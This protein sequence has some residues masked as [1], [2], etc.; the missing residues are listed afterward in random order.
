[1]AP[2]AASTPTRRAR[3]WRGAVLCALLPVAA[4]Q[5]LQYCTL[6]ENLGDVTMINGHGAN[7]S[8]PFMWC[9]H[10]LNDT[11]SA[12]SSRIV[13]ASCSC[14]CNCVAGCII[15][16]MGAMGSGGGGA[17]SHQEPPPPHV[18]PHGPAP[19]QAQTLEAPPM[20]HTIRVWWLAI[21]VTFYA[22]A[23]AVM[24]AVYVKLRAKHTILFNE[25]RERG[26][27]ATDGDE[28][29][30]TGRRRGDRSSD[31]RSTDG[32][33]SKAR[34]TIGATVFGE[35]FSISKKELARKV[36]A[37]AGLYLS[38]LKQCGTFF[39]VHSFTTFPLLMIVY[40][41]ANG[42]EGLH[43]HAPPD[44]FF[45]FTSGNL[46]PRD[47]GAKGVCAFA[48]YALMISSVVFA[49]RRWKK[50]GNF[51]FANK[52]NTH[53]TTTVMISDFPREINNER[54]LESYFALACPQQVASMRVALDVH[55]LA[56]NVRHQNRCIKQINT[57]RR[58][59]EWLHCEDDWDGQTD[60]EL[61]A[62]A[63]HTLLL[64]E[65]AE[66]KNRWVELRKQ[67]VKG[68]GCA[69][70]TFVS[71]QCAA[72]FVYEARMNKG[73]VAGDCRISADVLN[74]L[75]RSQWKISM[76][77]LQ[78]DIYWENVAT[79]KNEQ[80]LRQ[81]GANAVLGAGILCFAGAVMAG[82]VFV[83]FDYMK[84]AHRLDP[85][86]CAPTEEQSNATVCQLN[87]YSREHCD[88][89]GCHYTGLREFLQSLHNSLGN[90]YYPVMIIP[91]PLAFMF[92]AETM[93]PLIQ[94][95]SGY[96]HTQTRTL[97][98][99]SYL[100]KCYFYYLGLHL[101]CGTYG[102]W[103]LAQHVHAH[104]KMRVFVDLAG[105]YFCNKFF[106]ES[107]FYMPLRVLAGYDFFFR[108]TREITPSEYGSAA[109]EDDR[110]NLLLQTLTV[111]KPDKYYEDSFDYSR[112]YGETIALFCIVQVYA[113]S[114][115]LI[116]PISSCWFMAKYVA[117]KY[118]L[119]RQYSRARISYGRRARMITKWTILSVVIGQFFL[120][121]FTSSIADGMEA[122]AATIKW[123]FYLSGVAYLAYSHR[124]IKIP[125]LGFEIDPV[126]FVMKRA[127]FEKF[128]PRQITNVV[129]NFQDEDEIADESESAVKRN[130]R[131]RGPQSAI[132]IEEYNVPT[133]KSL[134]PTEELLEPPG[135]EHNVHNP[136]IASW[137]EDDQEL[138]A[139]GANGVYDEGSGGGA[140]QQPAHATKKEISFAGAAGGG[141]QVATDA[142]L[143]YSPQ[144]PRDLT[145]QAYASELAAGVGH[146][147]DSSW[148]S[149]ADWQAD[150]DQ[151][152]P[153]PS[154]EDFGSPMRGGRDSL[155]GSA[156]RSVRYTE[157]EIEEEV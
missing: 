24:M 19:L 114:V 62:R 150:R 10:E 136:M 69:F 47:R 132:E 157:A 27:I 109:E 156:N 111:F 81:I 43:E 155:V 9:E 110:K 83:G 22:L 42:A 40:S 33:N 84:W 138:P 23:C 101:G 120:W 115:P 122:E 139:G 71:E 32:S 61:D 3:V 108:P 124:K 135:T 5:R 2:S 151:D 118:I 52:I 148:D 36:G 35:F 14:S 74:A 76:A 8:C 64:R 38:H 79:S 102:W 21:P 49:Y 80:T 34:R 82:I 65:L 96:E 104:N 73:Y 92:C 126:T 45:T 89:A 146:D 78:H 119:A 87:D 15:P 31:P 28:L 90:W 100:T 154:D 143:E 57:L 6:V 129:N 70:I 113:I 149:D 37:D 107:L 50:L 63:D 85:E 16:G 46:G 44:A 7:E 152:G 25:M 29:R 147:S 128:M 105:L 121:Y 68:G 86:S 130:A 106:L 39:M 133:M 112:Q 103:Y 88:E 77:P 134:Q 56:M 58:S 140:Y 66:L 67:A 125:V 137:D 4:A 95:I 93:C 127:R 153:S 145:S 117:D 142:T 123:S 48:A 41:S 94:W 30:A 20:S 144:R 17:H 26:E 91:A 13:R 60:E 59:H 99:V 97:K 54:L 75:R 11:R 1:M 55:D 141:P 51:K 116:I 72:K 18:P 53:S 131:R 98:Q 12:R